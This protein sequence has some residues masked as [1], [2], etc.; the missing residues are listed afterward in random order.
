MYV[1]CCWGWTT[2]LHSL[3]D[4][5][6]LCLSVCVLPHTTDYLVIV[7]TY[8]LLIVI[9]TIAFTLFMLNASANLHNRMF[10]KVLYAPMRFFCAYHCVLARVLLRHTLC[11]L[12]LTGSLFVVQ[13]H[14]QRAPS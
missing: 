12:W 4:T 14:T 5:H 1:P 8:T 10:A 2:Y 13:G 11:R 6:L 3:A 7:V 9:R